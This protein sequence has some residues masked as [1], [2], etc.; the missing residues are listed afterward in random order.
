MDETVAMT[1]AAIFRAPSLYGNVE[2][3]H[4][5]LE[6]RNAHNVLDHFS[7]LLLGRFPFY[8]GSKYGKTDNLQKELH[9]KIN[10]KT[11]KQF[12]KTSKTCPSSLFRKDYWA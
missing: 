3:V 12:K 6:P 5:A 2:V 4:H 8:W 1:G 11:K 7:G 10:Q 9:G